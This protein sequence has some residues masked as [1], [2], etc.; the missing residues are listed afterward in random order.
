MHG[1]HGMYECLSDL[2][3]CERVRVKGEGRSGSGY[4]GG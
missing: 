3:V 1:L 4:L 2:F